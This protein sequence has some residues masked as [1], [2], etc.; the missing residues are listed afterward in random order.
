MATSRS[1]TGFWL[2]HA[3]GLPGGLAAPL[4]ELTSMVRAGRLKLIDGGSYPLADAAKAHD[5]LR[6]RRSTG[7]LTLEVSAPADLR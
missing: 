4:E 7:K 3:L 5:E 2:V 6:S 1:V